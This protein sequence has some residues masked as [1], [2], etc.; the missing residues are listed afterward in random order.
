[1]EPLP[2]MAAPPHERPA[3]AS[4]SWAAHLSTWPDRAGQETR[5]LLPVAARALRMTVVLVFL[6]GI[7][8]PLLVFAIGQV[9]F[10]AQANGSLL[11]D[12]H[13]RVIGSSLI[14]QQFTQP[15]YFHGRPSAVAYNA[16]GSGSSAIGPTNPQLL[17]GNGAE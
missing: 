10:P 5:S 11:T 2:P 12:A 13:G 15:F 16:A 9:A 3:T 1:M 17:T 7:V 14:G 8:F 4:R 6:C